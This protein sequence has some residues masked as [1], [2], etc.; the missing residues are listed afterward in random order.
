MPEAP[1][2]AR[3]RADAEAL[4]WIVT[5]QEAPED[6]EAR[7]RF[8]QWRAASPANAAAWEESARI[9]EAIGETNPIHSERWE[10]LTGQRKPAP[11]HPVAAFRKHRVQRSTAMPAKRRNGRRLVKA[12]L[13]AAVAAILAVLAAPELALRWQADAMAGTGE[14]RELTLADGSHASLS[15]GSAIRI[16]YS[17]DERRITLL[18]GQ[19][20]FEVHDDAR[21][22]RVAARDVEATDIGTAFEVGLAGDD[23]HVAVG[24]GIVRVDDTKTARVISK[25]LTAGQSVS[26]DPGGNIRRDTASPELIGAWR[27]GQ[28]AV[29][30]KPMS[31]VVEALRPWYGGMIVVRSNALADRHVTGVYDLHD[32]AGAMEALTKAYGGS[33]TRLTPWLIILSD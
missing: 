28:L 11:T 5:L 21:P 27:D 26:I 4:E 10:R 30:D 12:A 19:A 23:I 6:A 29:Q 18:R 15:P 32:P 25:R 1:D 3:K 16:D 33:V 13:P 24:H 22:F 31:D 9:Y 14:L 17:N 2:S 20:W 7:A 8:E